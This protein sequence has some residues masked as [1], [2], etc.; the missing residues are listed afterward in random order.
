MMRMKLLKVKDS[1]RRIQEGFVA[2]YTDTGQISKFAVA[3]N[4][5]SKERPH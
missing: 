5:A 1:E 4:L 3:V 2:L